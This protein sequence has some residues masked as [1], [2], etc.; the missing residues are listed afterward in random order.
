MH[1]DYTES[2]TR[3][4]LPP[5]WTP[6]MDASTATSE[7][8]PSTTPR[9]KPST[10]TLPGSLRAECC[11]V[12]AAGHRG[13]RSRR[14]S[15]AFGEDHAGTSHRTSS[16]DRTSVHRRPSAA[17]PLRRRLL[18]LECTTTPPAAAP[19]RWGRRHGSTRRVRRD[20]PHRGSS[21]ADRRR[22]RA[23][24]ACGRP[25]HRRAGRPRP[26]EGVVEQVIR[27]P[28]SRSTSPD[29]TLAERNAVERPARPPKVLTRASRVGLDADA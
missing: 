14:L 21:L 2:T 3:A 10:A 9:A 4:V 12:R 1:P 23:A 5:P 24:R 6:S 22:L 16:I 28:I 20:H 27:A 7:D 26:D 19:P 8:P 13:V 11:A 29:R 15:M 17:Q 25:L 18:V